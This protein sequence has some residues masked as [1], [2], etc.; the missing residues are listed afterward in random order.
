[1]MCPPRDCRHFRARWQGVQV[2]GGGRQAVPSGPPPP[3]QPHSKAVSSRTGR[4]PCAIT[5]PQVAWGGETAMPDQP[6]IHVYGTDHSPW[7]QS[8]VLTLEAKQLKYTFLSSPG[9]ST[10][11]L[12]DAVWLRPFIALAFF[13]SLIGA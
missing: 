5:S 1:M 2:V 13:V 9:P 4:T 12:L 3:P 11:P 6:V 10:P 8:V 7:V